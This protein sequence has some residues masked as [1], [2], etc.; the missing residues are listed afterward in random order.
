MSRQPTARGPAVRP[1]ALLGWLPGRVAATAY[2]AALG[3][4]ALAEAIVAALVA[5]VAVLA[6]LGVGL[7]LITPAVL[8]VRQL[9]ELTRRL[10][11]RWCGVPIA[12]PYLSPPGAEGGNGAEISSWQQ[13]RWLLTDP[14][15]RRDLLWLVLNPLV[16]AVLAAG[17][18]A[19][20]VYGIFGMA[21]PHGSTQLAG[22]VSHP[23]Y[24]ILLALAGF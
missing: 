12:A 19:A 15:T 5:A 17:P 2:G 20:I 10:C 13:R 21:L 24:G 23:L 9:A 8:A 14:A 22:T 3:L 11:G 4:L 18:A 7:P 16:G 6:G 1:D